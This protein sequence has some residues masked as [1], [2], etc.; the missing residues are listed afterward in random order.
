MSDFFIN[1]DQEFG[2][3]DAGMPED[4]FMEYNEDTYDVLGSVYLREMN[5]KVSQSGE[6]RV[7]EHECRFDNIS[8]SMFQ[9]A[10][11]WWFVMEYND[12]IDWN[13]KAEKIIKIP[14]FGE[15][16]ELKDSMVSRQNLANLAKSAQ[17]YL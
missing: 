14:N 16:F 9:T 4:A 15:I 6:M 7:A 13:I 8:H 5:T 11:F 17:I 10:G 1:L 3:L 2:D 12:Y